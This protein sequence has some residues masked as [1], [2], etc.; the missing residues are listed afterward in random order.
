ME[1]RIKSYFSK[2]YKRGKLDIG[3]GYETNPI[4]QISSIVEFFA[5]TELDSE[6]KLTLHLKSWWSTTYNRPL[7][8][9]LLDSYTLEEL[10]YEYY[11]KIERTK[12]ADRKA[13]QERD[14]MEEEKDRAALDWAEQEEKKELEQMAKLKD[15]SM[16][17][18]QWMQ[19]Q[20]PKEK[21]LYGEDF[22]D[23]ISFSMDGE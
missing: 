11:D 16:T 9:P 13:E 14:K 17:D 23:N 10:I 19:Q 1:R 12:A 22:G 2:G 15:P 3:V 4:S 5:N 7:K 6:L 18:E 21:E 8:D 20:L